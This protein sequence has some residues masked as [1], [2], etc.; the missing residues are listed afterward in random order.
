M[1]IYPTNIY[2]ESFIALALVFQ[3]RPKPATTLFIGY[4]I[5]E[6]LKIYNDGE[7]PLKLYAMLNRTLRI[8]RNHQSEPKPI[9]VDSG[10]SAIKYCV[11]DFS[12]HIP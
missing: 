1:N 7:N 2:P 8:N 5:Q 11:K 3:N 10:T 6:V 9:H 12:E 4:Q